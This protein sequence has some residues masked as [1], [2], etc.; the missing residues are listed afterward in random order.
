MGVQPI[1]WTI[2]GD[3]KLS[4]V[5]DPWPMDTGLVVKLWYAFWESWLANNLECKK[6]LQFLAE[7]LH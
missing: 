2:V 1:F 3:H 6:I 5:A 4:V 7:F